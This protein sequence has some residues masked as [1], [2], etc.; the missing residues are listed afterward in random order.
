MAFRPFARSDA[1]GRGAVPASL[2]QLGAEFG[3]KTPD[4]FAEGGLAQVQ[5]A[6]RPPKMQLLTENNKGPKLSNIHNLTLS[7]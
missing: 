2:E 5:E 4:L 3:F 7:P 6:R 1:S